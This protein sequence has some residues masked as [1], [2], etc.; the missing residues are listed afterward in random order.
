[1]IRLGKYHLCVLDLVTDNGLLSS[2]KIWRH[3]GY[4]VITY[5]FFNLID[6][7]VEWMVAYASIIVFDAG[8][9]AY[10]KRRYPVADEE[11]PEDRPRRRSNKLG[12]DR[13][14]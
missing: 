2:T 11:P 14:E 6:P 1:M 5:K 9:M 8:F 4:S 10:L 3:V 12:S 13:A 7:D